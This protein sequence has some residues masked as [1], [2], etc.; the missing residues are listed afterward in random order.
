MLPPQLS[1]VE[2][3]PEQ[4]HDDVERT[5][6]RA[7]VSGAGALYRDEC[8]GA[9]HVGEQTQ[10]VAGALELLWRYQPELGHDPRTVAESTR[11]PK[12]AATATSANIGVSGIENSACG[13]CERACTNSTAR[14]ARPSTT[15]AGHPRGRRSAIPM[16]ASTS[17]TTGAPGRSQLS[18]PSFAPSQ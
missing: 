3:P 16:A 4:V 8:V 13:S 6:A 15:S 2:L 1:D 5:E 11:F 12:I 17:Q 10:I 18:V 14:P 9:A 7:E